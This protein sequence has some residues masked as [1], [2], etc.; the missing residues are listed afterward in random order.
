MGHVHVMSEI[1]PAKFQASRAAAALVESGMAVGLGSGTTASLIIR[2]LGE[3]VRE[4]GLKFVGVPT[5]GATAMLARSLGIA[6]R[7]L[8]DVDT[9]DLNLDGADEID[10]EFRMIKGRGG[11]LLREKI[12]V[13]TAR[14]RVT[15]ITGEKRVDRLG[16]RMPVPVE[17]CEF[18]LRH[19]EARVAEL[20]AN[21]VIR[22]RP[23]GTTFLTDGGNAIIDC[24]FAQIDDP[25]ELD[26][27]LQSVAGVLG[28]G[29]FLELCDL[30]L[31]G[32]PNRVE[33]FEKPSRA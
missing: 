27:R 15:I 4:E 14:R 29:L 6:L 24:R 12:V 10:G 33:Q 8:D 13:S 18:G 25:S 30:L 1:D 19:T 3:R 11:A 2:R 21:T 22:R 32:Y 23:D 9:L 5:S 20:G 28:T 7:D 17:A 26:L 31:I 16:R